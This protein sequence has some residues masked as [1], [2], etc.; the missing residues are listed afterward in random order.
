MY[1]QTGKVLKIDSVD[2]LANPTGFKNL[3]GSKIG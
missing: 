3:S 1:Q 2:F